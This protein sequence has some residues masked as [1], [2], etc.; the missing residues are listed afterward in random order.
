MYFPVNIGYFPQDEGLR[1]ALAKVLTKTQR[2]KDHK[3]KK[4]KRGLL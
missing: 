2:Y 4:K 1:G 3:E